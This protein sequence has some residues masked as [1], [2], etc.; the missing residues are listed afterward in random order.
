M[1]RAFEDSE[2]SWRF[3]DPYEIGHYFGSL[4]T[5]KLTQ[6]IIAHINGRFRIID[7]QLVCL[8]FHS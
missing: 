2:L 6:D 4:V 3:I 1:L 5:E 7:T 8:S